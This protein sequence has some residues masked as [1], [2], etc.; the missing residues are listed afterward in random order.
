MRSEFLRMLNRRATRQVLSPRARYNDDASQLPTPRS[1]L[2][3][4]SPRE[5]LQATLLS[6]EGLIGQGL[7]RKMEEL[8]VAHIRQARE[9]GAGAQ[10]PSAAGRLIQLVQSCDYD[11]PSA[12]KHTAMQV[13]PL[14]FPRKVWT[15]WTAPDPEGVVFGWSDHVCLCLVGRDA[16][17]FA[18]EFT[19][20]ATKA[21]V[22]LLHRKVRFHQA[23]TGRTLRTVI[24][25]SAVIDPSVLPAARNF[26]FEIRPLLG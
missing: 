20:C 12:L 10:G 15:V 22:G 23:Q 16:Q 4:P 21:Q 5:Q 14:R 19:P 3:H 1:R 17:Q 26:G 9:N 25:L 2:A 11:D 24:I 6:A 18:L 13:M 8:V 7:S